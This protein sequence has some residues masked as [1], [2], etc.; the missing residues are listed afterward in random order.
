MKKRIIIGA[1]IVVAAG[2][3]I[4]GVAASRQKPEIASVKASLGDIS[5]D[6]LVTGTTKP[7]Q[8][9]DLSFER[10]GKVSAV[11][12]GVG[13]R[14]RAGQALVELEKG[15]ILAQLAEAQ[16]AVD[17]AQARLDQLKRGT[18]AEQV[19]VQEVTVANAQIAL[20]RSQQSLFDALNDAYAKAVDA[21]RTKTDE[22]FTNPRSATPILN[23]QPINPQHQIDLPNKK[24]AVERSIVEWES[25]LASLAVGSGLL[26][27]SSDAQARLSAITE[28]LDELLAALN[29]AT[30]GSAA[31]AEAWKINAAAARTSVS[32]AIAGLTAADTSLRSAQASL[33]LAEKNLALAKAGSTPEEIAAQQAVVDQYRA[34]VRGIE[35]SLGKTV[36]RS[37][38]DGTVTVQGAKLGQ[39]VTVTTASSANSALISVISEKKMEV[40][41]YAP[42]VNV[43][44]L[45]LGQEVKI[46]FDALPGETFS[47]SI[48]EIDPAETVIDGVVNYKIKV[49]L[50]SSDPRVKS[51]LTANLTIRTAVKE[52]VVLLPQNAILQNEEGTYVRKLEN[53]ETKEVPVKLGIRGTNGMVEIVS[54][55]APGDEVEDIGAKA[56]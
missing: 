11:H 6:I 7:I 10:T 26:S 18:R 42:E 54:G 41:A 25:S 27:A 15:D 34:G 31:N 35:V 36:L 50:D 23:F 52:K 20:A 3:V 49:A 47:G 2:L 24:Y 51:G 56:K 14:V 32:A 5:S 19:A 48:M 1:V 9:V 39:I 53:G 30:P 55:V 8:S 21:S 37:P 17:A 38:I 46:T 28:F 33:N 4:W 29:Y 45:A 43:G 12:V 16:A 44:R 13:D 22:N 40:D